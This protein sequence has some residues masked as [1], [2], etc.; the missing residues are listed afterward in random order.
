MVKVWQIVGGFSLGGSSVA[1]GAAIYVQLIEPEST[2]GRGMVRLLGRE[3][4]G[5]LY[6]CLGLVLLI[7]SVW[8]VLSRLRVNAR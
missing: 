8:M 7:A 3:G 6:I 4:A 2:Q 1:Y 5:V